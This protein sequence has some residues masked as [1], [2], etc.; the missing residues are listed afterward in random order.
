MSPPTNPP[1]RPYP[2]SLGQG[3]YTMIT[4]L[5]QGGIATVWRVLDSVLGIERALKLLD[6]EASRMAV[7][8]S[9][10]LTEARVMARLEH[11]NI[12]R[13]Y[14][15]GDE[16]GR[17]YLVMELID[18]GSVADLLRATQPLPEQRALRVAFDILS[19]LTV[20][21]A[22]GTIHR[23]V[24]PGNILIGLD[25]SARLSDFGIARL[26][27]ER[28]LHQELRTD[29]VGTI[30]YTAPEG[31]E[32]VT[33]L[34]PRA[35]LY[36]VGATLFAMITGRHPAVL[37]RLD[38]HPEYLDGMSKPTAAIVRAATR[39]DPSARPA[40]ARAMAIAVARAYDALTGPTG[41]P[42][43]AMWMRDLDASFAKTM[44]HVNAT[45]TRPPAPPRVD[46]STSVRRERSAAA[47][48]AQQHATVQT[49]TIALGVTSG[50]IA[51]AVLLLLALR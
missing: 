45:M 1:A 18:G 5:G 49:L 30:G 38:G 13:V 44:A 37:E 51:V 48:R 16:N 17:Y 35:D 43:E 32:S 11:P 4:L 41:G 50:V 24:K 19:A 6:D 28:P 25:G 39:R 36:G 22:T 9:R 21:H 8:R 15:Y 31:M 12:L 47:A 42:V 14:D 10:F 40:S 26:P 2:R 34:T 3:R 29:R 27:D 20:V 7:F 33:S 23:D 46:T